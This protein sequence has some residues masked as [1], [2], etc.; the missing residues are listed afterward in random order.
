MMTL[1]A[2]L[3]AGFGL[4]ILCF[5]ATGLYNYN[6]INEIEKSIYVQN[7]RSKLQKEVIELRSTV[8]QMNIWFAE[9]IITRSPEVAAKHK[10]THPAFFA[11]VEEI[12]SLGDELKERRT[13]QFLR[14]VSKEFAANL[15]R[16]EQVAANRTISPAETQEQL[17]QVFQAS[18]AHQDYI[19]SLIAVFHE[20]LSAQTNQAIITSENT[21]YE[22]ANMAWRFMALVLVI[23]LL[24]ASVI[25]VPLMRKVNT[26]QG[27]LKRI[28]DGDLTHRT[29]LTSSDE[30]GQLGKQFD[31]M[32]VQVGAM[33]VQTKQT[34]M[35]LKS[36]AGFFE[37]FSANTSAAN[38]SISSAMNEITAGASHQAS[39]LESSV[40]KIQWISEELHKV[41]E[42]SDIV[43]SS[44][45]DAT[46][47]AVAGA[48]TM[49]SLGKASARSEELI[50]DVNNAFKA[51]VAASE[52]I[53]IVMQTIMEISSQT[54]LLALNAAIESARA[55]QH[56]RGFS[57]I[58]EEVRKLS[59]Q[60]SLSSK[61]VRT[62]IDRLRNKIEH[63]NLQLNE[64][65]TAV[66]SQN[67][68]VEHA[69]HAF[70]RIHESLNTIVTHITQIDEGMDTA[71]EQAADF[72]RALGHVASISQQT[73]AGVEEITAITA[74]QSF[75]VQQIELGAKE[76]NESTGILLDEI[77]R[78]KLLEATTL[79]QSNNKE[80]F[81]PNPLTEKLDMDVQPN[82]TVEPE[83][84]NKNLTRD[85]PEQEA[86]TNHQNTLEQ[87]TSAVEEKIL[88]GAK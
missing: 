36:K 42:V 18:Q 22:T 32:V 11:K 75:A 40:T 53:D 23:S 9:F 77:A 25:I 78:F 3:I 82:L 33:L 81:V 49:T 74:E 1:K 56:G 55:G 84:I 39:E 4:L 51:L 13:A 57:I 63:A 83:Q 46:E 65:K 15:T 6:Q 30:L 26:L 29:D 72:V 73:A 38:T 87:P 86:Q 50:Y 10:D 58:A 70:R 71:S 16:A 35:S 37:Q 20:I 52:E 27:S 61:S 60:T 79:T 8:Q 62:T 76:I 7:E 34:A 5:A 80:Y 54:N 85:E 67:G 43:R 12:A 17:I 41:K 64:A 44:G 47:L 88:V 69:Q 48:S 68:L 59:D 31:Q 2:R 24:T 19:F 45:Y 21:L 14:T 66:V 28:A